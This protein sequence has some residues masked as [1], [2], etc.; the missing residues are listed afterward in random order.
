[1]G[2]KKERVVRKIIIFIFSKEHKAK[3]FC[4]LSKAFKWCI[5]VVFSQNRTTPP[6]SEFSLKS[7]KPPPH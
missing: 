3:E 2:G 6:P 7:Q 1:M 4:S 5:G